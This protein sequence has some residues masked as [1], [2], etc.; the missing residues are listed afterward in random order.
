MACS[1][2]LIIVA[3]RRSIISTPSE[4]VLARQLARLPSLNRSLDRGADI[5]RGFGATLSMRVGG[6]VDFDHHPL[7]VA[8][9]FERPDL[10]IG[11]RGAAILTD[12]ERLGGAKADRHDM[13][14]LGR[15][16]LGAV[17]RQG[18]RAAFAHSFPS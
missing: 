8:V 9:E 14:E 15:A 5:V 18:R 13:R 16:N 6:G 12:I 4:L 2:R 10:L 11:R 17:Y 7:E 3:E 1:R